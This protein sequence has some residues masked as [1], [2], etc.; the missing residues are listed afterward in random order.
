MLHANKKKNKIY[1]TTNTSFV[2]L[3]C[4]KLQQQCRYGEC[5]KPTA[6]HK[7]AV[8]V[9][10]LAWDDSFFFFVIKM[11]SLKKKKNPVNAQAAC[12]IC[13]VSDGQRRTKEDVE[14]SNER[15]LGGSDGKPRLC[16]PVAALS[17]SNCRYFTATPS[18]CEVSYLRCFSCARTEL[19]R[20]SRASAGPTAIKQNPSLCKRDEWDAAVLICLCQSLTVGSPKVFTSPSS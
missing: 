4:N 9:L 13:L 1:F 17:A 15:P 2:H 20:C 16:S 18:G 8:R 5:L 6:V 3:L 19:R 7:A 11:H 14:K 12:H 10:L